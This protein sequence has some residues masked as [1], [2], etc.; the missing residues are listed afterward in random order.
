[1]QVVDWPGLILLRAELQFALIEFVE[2][3]SPVPAISRV[4]CR[5]DVIVYGFE[6]TV[7]PLL[8]SV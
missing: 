1:M 5:L 7:L 6:S 8:M 3:E 4:F 2:F